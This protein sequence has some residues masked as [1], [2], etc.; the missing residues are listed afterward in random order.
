[1]RR[2]VEVKA[3]RRDEEVKK[4]GRCAQDQEQTLVLLS[5]FLPT[6][7][8]SISCAVGKEVGFFGPAGLQD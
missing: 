8:P 7:R 5:E 4:R 1:M 2:A 3:Y 6:A